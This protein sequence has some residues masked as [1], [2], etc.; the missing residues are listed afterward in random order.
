[1]AI[2]E[3]FRVINYE[4]NYNTIFDTKTTNYGIR[5][6]KYYKLYEPIC[7]KIIEIDK[8]YNYN[9]IYMLACIKKCYMKRNKL[10]SMILIG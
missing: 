3:Y 6:R 2:E 5:S 10:K 1:M 9:T 7:K 4:V 8:K